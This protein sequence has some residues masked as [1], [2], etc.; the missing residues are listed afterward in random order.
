LRLLGDLSA[1]L[2]NPEG[3]FGTEGVGR[4][5]HSN[6]RI[7]ALD[8]R[9]HRAVE[10]L[11]GEAV[12]D[13]CLDRAVADCAGVLWIAMWRR[14]V[15]VAHRACKRAEV[16]TITALLA[17]LAVCYCPIRCDPG[18]KSPV[19]EARVPTQGDG[20]ASWTA[21][22]APGHTPAAELD[23]A[24]FLDNPG[25]R[26]QTKRSRPKLPVAALQH[27]QSSLCARIRRS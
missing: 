26:G 2:S 9:D 6:P 3:A 12:I 15:P 18:L 21:M 20:L 22:A 4:Y 5:L 8:A 16:V 10:R 23:G 13:P 1:G 24:E 19:L 17:A 25:T 14:P 11:V 7:E 27:E